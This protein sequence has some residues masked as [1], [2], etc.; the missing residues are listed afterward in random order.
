MK[1]FIAIDSFKGTLS[2]HE[3][4]SMM[5][6][7]LINRHIDAEYLSVAD[8]GEGFLD[9]IEEVLSAKRIM[10]DV[11]N[12]IGELIKTY[13]LYDKTTQT[14]YIEL[15]KASGYMLL[16]PEQRN[17]VEASTYGFGQLID[18]AIANRATHIVLGL[19]GSATNDGGV[20]M[21]EALGCQ[22]FDYQSQ[23]I[24]GLNARKIGEIA[25][26]NQDFLIEKI[27]HVQ[28]KVVA[29]VKN[30]LL[31]KNGATRVYGPQK[32]LTSSM[33]T[34]FERHLRAYAR[35]LDPMAIW[36]WEPGSGASGGVGFACKACLQA[37][38][39]LGIDYILD[40]VHFEDHIKSA[41]YI[42]TGEG[43][44]DQQSLFGKV[45]GGII[46]RSD[47]K[48]VIVVCGVNNI[49]STLPKEIVKVVSIVPQIT[50]YDEALLHAHEYFKK[51]CE[52]IVL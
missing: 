48:K 13:Y 22:F 8:G 45:V 38:C 44:F 33:I 42:I 49:G 28:F 4:G 2:S 31:G 35:L 24:Q 11:F 23:R 52:L 12:P 1:V 19:G 6:S 27:K 40:L 17:P 32:G 20:G 30:P 9:A 10:C 16:A 46:K 39:E 3:V 51:L 43:T 34:E 26:I 47:N 18:Q 36:Q 21:L 41:D 15:A 50:T 37:T 14:A 5:A 7:S 29:D 25:T